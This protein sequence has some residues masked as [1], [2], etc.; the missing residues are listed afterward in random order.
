[1]KQVGNKAS[2]RAEKVTPPS[3]FQ[4]GFPVKAGQDSKGVFVEVGL[5]G[6]KKRVK[7]YNWVDKG[8][9]PYKIRAKRA[10]MLSFLSRYKPI[11]KRGGFSGGAGKGFPPRVF[12]KEVNHPG[13]KARDFRGEV[14]KVG[15]AEMKKLLPAAVKRGMKK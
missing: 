8:T 4:V 5:K 9:R 12:A 6:S 11:T 2:K 13:I 1:M 14:A 10:P 3:R 7:I 15:N